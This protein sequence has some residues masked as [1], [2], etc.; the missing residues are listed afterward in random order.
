[1]RSRI[2]RESGHRSGAGEFCIPQRPST[3]RHPT[4]IT[5]TWDTA[6]RQAIP[7][8]RVLSLDELNDSTPQILGAIADA[9]GSDDPALIRELVRCARTR[10][11]R[12]FGCS[13]TSST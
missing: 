6:V 7:H 8:M 3:D 1:M 9:L 12:G 11:S 5:L 2:H 10:V 4:W 13:S